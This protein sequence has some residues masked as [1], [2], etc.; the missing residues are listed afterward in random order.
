MLTFPFPSWFF[1]NLLKTL[2]ATKWDHVGFIME[3]GK[4][5]AVLFDTWPKDRP[6]NQTAE[7]VAEAILL[8]LGLSS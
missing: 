1:E 7:S 5:K 4:P 3:N 2:Q 6:Q 8:K